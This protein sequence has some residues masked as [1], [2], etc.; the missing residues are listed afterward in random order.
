[1][2]CVTGAPVLPVGFAAIRCSDPR[3]SGDVWKPKTQ[4]GGTPNQVMGECGVKYIDK[5]YPYTLDLLP[6]GD[7]VDWGFDAWRKEEKGSK[8]AI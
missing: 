6:V 3:R 5:P 4:M 7:E 2:M 8:E 1:M